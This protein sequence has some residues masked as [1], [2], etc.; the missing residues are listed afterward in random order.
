MAV[1]VT[2]VCLCKGQLHEGIVTTVYMTLEW[3]GGVLYACTLILV[4][5]CTSNPVLGPMY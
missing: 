2:S 5:W 1:L 3:C 4:Q